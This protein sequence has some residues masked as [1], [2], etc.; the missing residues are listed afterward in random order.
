MDGFVV[1]VTLPGTPERFTETCSGPVTIGRSEGCDIQLGHPAVSR[2]H[3]LV[4]QE[5]DGRFMVRDLGSRNGTTVNGKV[6][7][8]AHSIVE[9]EV[10]VQVGPYVLL[11]APPSTSNG[12]TV[13]VDTR[14]Q[15][16]RLTLDRGLRALLLDGKVIIE[17]LSVLEYRLLDALASS[18]PRIVENKVLGDAV[19]GGGQWDI[20]M[21]HNLVRRIR[22]KLEEAGI[23]A[24]E[25]LATAPGMGYRL[26]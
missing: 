4:S 22:R 23:E 20:Y 16:T 15:T 25:L 17:R 7:R 8:D 21:L 2:R 18:A 24:E 14:Q 6:L 12:T 9:G 19:W 26:A 13:L 5:D 1:V 10:T 3:A 11:L